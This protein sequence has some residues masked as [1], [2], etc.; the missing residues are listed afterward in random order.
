MKNYRDMSPDEIEQDITKTRAHIDRTLDVLAARL[1]P[2]S[3]VDQAL[4][5]ARDTGG[6][7]TLNLG[8]T[9]RDNPVPTALL[10]VGLGWLML[11][12]RRD[13]NGGGY[14]E[15]YD[16]IEEAYE[17]RRSYQVSPSGLAPT[18]T[19]ETSDLDVPEDWS[20][21]YEAQGEVDAE[22]QPSG[23]DRVQATKAAGKEAYQ[24]VRSGATGASAKL[25]ATAQ[26]GTH[27]ARDA[28]DRA[29][30]SAR[31][32]RE[33]LGE[34]GRRT[35]ERAR[36]MA[37]GLSD[38]ASATAARAKLYGSSVTDRASDAYRRGGDAARE[39]SYRAREAAGSAGSFAREHPI[40]VGLGIAALGAAIAA[41]LPRTRRE[42]EIMGE[43][44]EQVKAAARE[45][46]EIQAE[47][48]RDAAAA[49]VEAGKQQAREAGLTPEGIKERLNET[50]AAAA[51]VA[52]S[53]AEAGTGKAKEGAGKASG[54]QAEPSEKGKASKPA[55]GP[56]VV[57]EPITP[58]SGSPQPS[59]PP[60][61]SPTGGVAGV[62]G[63]P[64]PPAQGGSFGS[65]MDSRP[66][67]PPQP[68]AAPAQKA[69]EKK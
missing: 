36:E 65:T 52:R 11:A 3:L 18:S 34:S 41:F 10:G 33:R 6:E 39:A 31:G 29:K 49:A 68:G 32:M 9:I 26:Q 47:R 37:Y 22:G 60:A 64:T 48:A 2:G 63:I 23:G 53:A 17:P 20:A 25:A 21:A 67:S 50:A 59:T 42:D 46:A 43:K 38:R 12:G 69:D 13:G 7:F 27:A 5:T 24:Q 45:Q 1:S 54:G 40:A 61:T 62:S 58:A 8:R 16:D 14:I 51:N 4:R 30:A 66:V 56:G 44:A 19:L 57:T 35:S 15:H 55:A 28:A